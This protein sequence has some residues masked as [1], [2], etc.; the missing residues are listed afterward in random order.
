MLFVPP[1]CER[2][3]ASSSVDMY[4]STP[5][6]RTRLVTSNENHVRKSVG[7]RV[8]DAALSPSEPEPVLHGNQASVSSRGARAAGLR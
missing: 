8:D 2:P 3:S 4:R 6:G 5:A 1:S 7:T